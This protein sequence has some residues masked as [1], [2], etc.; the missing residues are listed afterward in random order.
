MTDPI[1][2]SMRDSIAEADAVVAAIDPRLT[3]P[4][5]EVRDVVLVVGPWLAGATSVLAALRE[6]MP[7]H[8]FIEFDGSTCR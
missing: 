1:A 4:G 7:G 8:T 3:A 6:L 5:I 2:G